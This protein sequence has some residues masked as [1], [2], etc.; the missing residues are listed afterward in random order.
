FVDAEVR[1]LI[2]FDLV[3]AYGSQP[4]MSSDEERAMAQKFGCHTLEQM[5]NKAREM[6]HDRREREQQ[7]KA[8][9]F[10]KLLEQNLKP[11]NLQKLQMFM[12]A[13]CGQRYLSNALN[14]RHP[15]GIGFDF[16]VAL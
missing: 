13:D 6:S 4:W 10:A 9:D 15:N 11:P 5:R 16:P 12:S 2:A 14:G 1:E 8:L 3:F 7:A